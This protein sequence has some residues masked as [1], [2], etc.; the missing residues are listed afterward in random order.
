MPRTSTATA[1]S[2]QTPEAQ[3]AGL[4]LTRENLKARQSAVAVEVEAAL[5]ARRRALIEGASA[6]EAAEAERACREIEGT[7]FGITDALAELD[8]RILA[9]EERIEA[10]RTAARVEAVAA[11][12]ER[13]SVAI[14]AAAE[15]VRRAVEVLAKA[16]EAFA[17]AITPTAAPLFTKRDMHGVRDGEPPERVAAFLVGHMIAGALPLIEVSEAGRHEQYGYVSA[18]PIEATAGDDP[19]KALL[20][21]PMRAQAAA[22]RGGEAPPTLAQYHR[23]EPNFEPDREEIEVY[24]TSRFSYLK[25]TGY[26]PEIVSIRQQHLPIPVAEAAIEQGVAERNMPANWSNVMRAAQARAGDSYSIFE[27]PPLG[28]NLEEWRAA[29]TKRRREAWLAERQQAA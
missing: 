7:A 27:V 20:T 11:E 8:R 4:T 26:V 17:A 28:F 3:L 12:L 15:K 21:G 19:A 13:D 23:P 18:R 29:E 22:V 9:T 25:K 16:S 5:A 10:D 14:D 1:K 2:E 6:A 24:V